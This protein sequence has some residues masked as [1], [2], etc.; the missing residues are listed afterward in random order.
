MLMFDKYLSYAEP[1]VDIL[2]VSLHQ[3]G[4]PLCGIVGFVF[5]VRSSELLARALDV[6]Q[7]SDFRCTGSNPDVTGTEFA[8]KTCDDVVIHILILAVNQC[9][10]AD[11][12]DEFDVEVC[13]T[14]LNTEKSPPKQQFDYIICR[15]TLQA[16]AAVWSQF[17]DVPLLF[18]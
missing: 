11:F 12:A 9:H 8:R 6:V 10:R 4:L 3:N 17:A 15:C 7:S 13:H 18:G 16:I 14:N 1:A 5:L 2:A